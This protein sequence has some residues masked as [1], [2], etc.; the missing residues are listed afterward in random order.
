MLQYSDLYEIY[1]PLE[2]LCTFK[3]LL[4]YG[5]IKFRLFIEEHTNTWR[6]NLQTAPLRIKVF[7]KKNPCRGIFYIRNNKK[8][9][10]DGKKGFSYG[11]S[12]RSTA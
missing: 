3:N 11:L 8:P 1:F 7:M 5:E 9:P 12:C 2:K 10:E 4:K 6:K